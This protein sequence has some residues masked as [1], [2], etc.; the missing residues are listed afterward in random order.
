MSNYGNVTKAKWLQ[1][2]TKIG[3]NSDPYHIFQEIGTLF[4]CTVLSLLQLWYQLL[5]HYVI[6]SP[7]LFKAAP[8]ALE[9]SNDYPSRSEITNVTLNDMGETNQCQTTTNH[10]KV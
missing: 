7:T 1:S 4:C 3:H 10:K 5:V 2:D 6:N 9:Q 8:L